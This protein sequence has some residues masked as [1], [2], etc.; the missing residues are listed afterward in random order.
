MAKRITQEEFLNKVTS[1]CGDNIDFSKSVYINDA[2]KVMC[3]C[4]KCDNIW[5]VTPNNLKHGK[6]CPSCKH[7]SKKY[8]LDEWFKMAEKAHNGKYDL[9]LINEY[10]SR[11]QKMKIICHEK[12][13]DGK[14]HG[15]FEISSSSFLHGRGCPYCAINVIKEKQKKP[16]D[17]MVKDARKIHGDKYEYNEDTYVN[18]QTP[19]KIFCKVHG[20]FWQTPHKHI[21]GKHGCPKCKESK[22]EGE[23]SKLL[24]K[25]NVKYVEK[26]HFEWL[27]LQ[28]LD[29]Y[30]PEYN[31]AIECQGEQHYEGKSFSSD[32]T[33][34]TLTENLKIQQERDSRKK[35]LCK[36]N[37]VKLL[38]FTHYKNISEDE[39]TFKNKE[40]L[41][42]KIF[43]YEKL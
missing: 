25:N 37:N 27:G 7:K 17:Q 41:L 19:M 33:K 22:L 21:N 10:H 8:T 1:I 42:N 4:K 30:L 28:H 31:V 11:E 13:L 36:R 2:T 20:E 3:I 35:K 14:E 39:V 5:W 43:T 23:I 9:S 38:Y 16:F 32:K 6:G 26:K 18:A 15:V 12:H 40:K 29:F 34:K 24:S